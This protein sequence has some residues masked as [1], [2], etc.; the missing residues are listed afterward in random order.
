MPEHGPGAKNV[1]KGLKHALPDQGP[2]TKLV[3]KGLKLALP[4]IAERNERDARERKLVSLMGDGKTLFEH[5]ILQIPAINVVAQ[6]LHHLHRPLYDSAVLTI[7]VSRRKAAGT[8][9]APKY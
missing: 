7:Y 1:L 6:S 4:R 2:G 9:S 5:F 3:L 8:F